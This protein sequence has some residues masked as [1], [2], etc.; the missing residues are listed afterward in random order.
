LKRGLPSLGIPVIR[1]I[2]GG[3]L[4]YPMFVRNICD[5]STMRLS[6]RTREQ[7]DI[8]CANPSSQL[9]YIFLKKHKAMIE[10]KKKMHHIT[11]F[12]GCASLVL[13][14]TKKFASVSITMLVM[15]HIR[16]MN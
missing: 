11:L 13:H 1:T 3:K 9:I 4:K 15:V 16:N 7:E 10:V 5:S 8:I 6:D 14:K 12:H 2:N